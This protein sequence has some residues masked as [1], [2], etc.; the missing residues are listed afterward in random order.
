MIKNE[1]VICAT[2]FIVWF[3]HVEKT[4]SVF[5]FLWVIKFEL[6]GTSISD[7][8]VLSS[9]MTG[10]LRPRDIKYSANTSTKHCAF[11]LHYPNLK[12]FIIFKPFNFPWKQLLILFS[13]LKL[14]NWRLKVV[15]FPMDHT[16][17]TPMSP[18]VPMCLS[19]WLHDH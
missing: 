12:Q 7:R 1:C 14:K 6:G 5:F 9:Y 16:S 2:R 15:D 11:S 18:S 4:D 3:L 17:R 19:V 10:V 13:I 8:S